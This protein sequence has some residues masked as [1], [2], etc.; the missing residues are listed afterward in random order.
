MARGKFAVSPGGHAVPDVVHSLTL[1]R[2]AG[3]PLRGDVNLWVRMQYQIVRVEDAER[4]PWK[5]STCAYDHVLQRRDGT[6]IISFHWHPAGNS[7]VKQPHIHLGAAELSS[8]G[9][10]SHK[11]HVPTS[12]VA[13]EDVIAFAI[14]DLRVEPLTGSWPEILNETRDA[15]VRYRSWASDLNA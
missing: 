2:D 6:E 11:A 9:V 13:L 4:G 1:N 8:S 5:V 10:L 14:T 3:A 15:F 7:W 12:R